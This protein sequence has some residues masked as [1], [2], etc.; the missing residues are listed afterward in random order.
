V[1]RFTKSSVCFF[2]LLTKN[3]EIAN[4]QYFVL[5]TAVA[6]SVWPDFTPAVASGCTITETLHFFNGATNTW[7]NYADAPTDYPFVQ[8]FG[9][10]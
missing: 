7:V 1:L 6:D 2:D 9:K 8:N 10:D 3:A 4:L 5:G